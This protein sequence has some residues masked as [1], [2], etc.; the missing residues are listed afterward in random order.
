VK[1]Y[2]RR[3]LHEPP[4]PIRAKRRDLARVALVASGLV[5]RRR[6]GSGRNIAR[7][8]TNH[9]SAGVPRTGSTDRLRRL[10]QGTC[11]H[12]CRD[13]AALRGQRLRS[14]SQRRLV[15]SRAN[16]V[17]RASQALLGAAFLGE[18]YFCPT[19]ATSQTRRY[20]NISRIMNYRHQPVVLP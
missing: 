3:F 4:R 10:G 11:P 15:A 7:A 2:K 16:G 5:E 20:F 9:H 17:S 18:C 14:A 19:P 6:Q 8:D 13:T 12:F 1:D